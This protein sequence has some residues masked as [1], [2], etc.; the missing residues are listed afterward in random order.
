MKKVGLITS[1]L[2]PLLTADDRLAFG[3]LKERGILASALIWD[4]PHDLSEF[5]GLVFRSCW[6]QRRP[7]A[8]A[9]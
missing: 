2:D 1:D 9:T 6:K 3:P 8:E 4:Q 7:E 5:D